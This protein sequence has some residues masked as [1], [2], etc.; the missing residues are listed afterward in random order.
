MDFTK[1][2][3]MLEEGVDEKATPINE[4]MMHGENVPDSVKKK[5]GF[6]WAYVPEKY[7]KMIG[8]IK[9]SDDLTHDKWQVIDF[10]P[11]SKSAE[12]A[13][14]GMESE[15]GESL[16][17][18]ESVDFDQYVEVSRSDEINYKELLGRIK[19][20]LKNKTIDVLHKSGQQLRTKK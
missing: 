3:E 16:E 8:L 14:K 17:I 18:N 13:K 7:N 10:E 12:T 11:R 1:F 5:Y 4:A 15:F 20:L 6:K 2:I 19:A 9:D